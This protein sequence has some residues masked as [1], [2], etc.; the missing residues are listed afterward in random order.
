MICFFFFRF[1]LFIDFLMLFLCHFLAFVTYFNSSSIFMIIVFKFLS[2]RSTIMGSFCLFVFGHTHGMWKFPGQGLNPCHNSD[3]SCCSDN[4]GSLIFFCATEELY[5]RPFSGTVSIV[6]LWFCFAFEWTILS[7]FFVWCVPFFGH[8]WKA[9]IWSNNMVTLEIKTFPFP[10]VEG[11]F[12]FV[13]LCFVLLFFVFW[14]FF[15]FF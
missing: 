6:G 14:V 15:F 2:S 13:V 11:F 1:F 10:T 12:C 8:C 5:I 4:A 9:D 3:P 7:C